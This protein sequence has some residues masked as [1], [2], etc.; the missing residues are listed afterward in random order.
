MSPSRRIF[1]FGA[2]V[3]LVVALPAAFTFYTDWLWFGEMGYQDVFVR[4]LT[5]QG[6]LGG[7][8]MALA[9]GVLLLNLRLAMRMISPRSLVLPPS[10]GPITIAIDRPRLQPLGTAA[11]A[12]LALLFGVFASAQW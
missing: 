9:F 7:A 4:K 10:Q 6:T 11:A 1:V 3:V 5:A 12:A 8:A 2:I